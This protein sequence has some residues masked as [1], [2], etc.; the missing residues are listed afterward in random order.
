[1]KELEIIKLELKKY[2]NDSK[3]W[4]LSYDECEKL[5]DN[6][7]IKES[8][9][10]I[11]KD[12][13][14]ITENELRDISTNSNILNIFEIYLMLNDIL[15]NDGTKEDY[16]ISTNELSC[17]NKYLDDIGKSPLLTREEEIDLAIK[18]KQG[19]LIAKEKFIK[20]NLRLVISV[21]KRY[22]GRGMSLEDLIQE[23]NIGLILAV[24]KFDI[25]RG[26]KFSTCAIWW[27]RQSIS[28]AVADQAR[29]IRIPVHAVE[30][31]NKYKRL[32]E[33]M[34]QKGNVTDEDIARE[35]EISPG[36][37]KD[38]IYKSQ[39]ITSLNTVIGEDG[40]STL[41]DFIPDETNVEQMAIMNSGLKSEIQKALSYMNERERKI[42][43][44]RFGFY[45]G[46][47]HTLEYVGQIFG[48]T[49]ER[50]RQI[51]G[52]TL[53]KLRRTSKNLKEYL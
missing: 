42:I 40:D 2:F 10:V 35:L 6:K 22:R 25:N 48:V 7:K 52:K 18:I 53:R 32:K 45:D 47:P 37:L 28:R 50:I 46:N 11:F 49:R 31:L 13:T 34:G 27:I 5:C 12:K 14:E 8:L 29:T 33:Q 3:E 4:K 9:E 16:N 51:E 1:M 39:E 36:I 19:D 15:V 17:L 24:D 41:E 44:L 43:E 20:S 38:L 30:L 21:A 26:C 23:G